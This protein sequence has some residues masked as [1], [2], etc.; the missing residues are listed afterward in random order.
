M[1]KY[2]NKLRRKPRFRRTR[3]FL[4]MCCFFAITAL[5]FRLFSYNNP[6]GE[7]KQPIIQNSVKDMNNTDF[8]THSVNNE[9]NYVDETTWCLTLVNKWNYIPDNYEVELMKLA[10]GESVDKRIYPALQEMLDAARHDNI[11]SVVAS[12]YRTTEKQQSLMDKKIADYRDEGYSLKKATAKSEE[13]VA[14]PGTSEHQ[15]GLGVDFNADG[16]HSTGEEVYEWLGQ[17]SYKFG[18]VRR[19]SADKKDITGINDEPW[20]YRYVGIEAATKMYNQ[21]ICL[22]EYLTMI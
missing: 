3:L 20:H 4:L 19:Y 7:G 16:I 9:G 21:G 15:L 17:N 10:N 18:F 6:F 13:W 8:R 14:I 1:K 5:A 11:Y 12:G 22:E 2:S